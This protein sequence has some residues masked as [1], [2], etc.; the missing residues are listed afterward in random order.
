MAG[1]ARRSDGHVPMLQGHATSRAL[2][3]PAPSPR[4]TGGDERGAGRPG[5]EPQAPTPR[6]KS[7]SAKDL[8]LGARRGEKGER[9]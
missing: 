3:G 4:A 9:G 2:R 6:L 8:S 7:A 1:R 5:G